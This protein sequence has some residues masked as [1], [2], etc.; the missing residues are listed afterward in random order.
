VATRAAATR[1]AATRAAAI[2]VVEIPGAA[3]GAIPG[4]IA[5]LVMAAG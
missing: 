3:M 2:R 4:A 1:A 5:I